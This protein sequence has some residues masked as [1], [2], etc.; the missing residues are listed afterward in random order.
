MVGKNYYTL[1]TR[2]SR[3]LRSHIV[4][5]SS[6]TPIILMGNLKFFVKIYL[7]WYRCSSGILVIKKAKIL[8]NEVKNPNNDIDFKKIK[9]YNNIMDIFFKKTNIKA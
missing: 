3:A 6:Y 7:G 9:R 4:K 5:E 1:T 2:H 8:K